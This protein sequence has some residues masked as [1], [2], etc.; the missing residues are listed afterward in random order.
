M[1]VR[2][3]CKLPKEFPDWNYICVNISWTFYILF[4]SDAS[5]QWPNYRPEIDK[6]ENYFALNQQFIYY[7]LE[8]GIDFYLTPPCILLIEYFSVSLLRDHKNQLVN[9]IILIM[10]SI[11]K[12]CLKVSPGIFEEALHPLV[13]YHMSREST[14]CYSTQCLLPLLIVNNS[15]SISHLHGY[16]PLIFL[17]HIVLDDKNL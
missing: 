16:L 11:Q 12:L 15:V 13:G 1:T 9:N 7:S 10:I 14:L 2:H 3:L 8:I 4:D 17:L 6:E 5:F